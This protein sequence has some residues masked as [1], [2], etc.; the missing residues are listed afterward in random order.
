MATFDVV[1]ERATACGLVSD[2]FPE[3]DSSQLRAK[4]DVH[5]MRRVGKGTPGHDRKDGYRVPANSFHGH[6]ACVTMNA[7][8]CVI[9]HM[10]ITSGNLNNGRIF[11]Q[12]LDWHT[13]S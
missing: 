5:R 1:V 4:L 9:T 13:G 12:V 2:A 11:W 3:V 6:K 10:V 7:G 8:N